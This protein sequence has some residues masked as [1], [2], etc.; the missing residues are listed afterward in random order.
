MNIFEFLKI[1][2]L[3]SPLDYKL[4]DIFQSTSNNKLKRKVF[5]AM[6]W[7]WIKSK[8]KKL[9]KQL[10][11]AKDEILELKTKLCKFDNEKLDSILQKANLAKGKKNSKDN[12]KAKEEDKNEVILPAKLNQPTLVKNSIE[13]LVKTIISSNIISKPAQKE[14][15]CII[16]KQNF[17]NLLN[18]FSW[19]E[20]E[21]MSILLSTPWNRVI[22]GENI[23]YKQQDLLLLRWAAYIISSGLKVFQK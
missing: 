18:V 7:F 17:K 1:Y 16:P 10:S 22:K 5:H 4:A 19:T 6:S 9:A 23:Y 12:N 2:T 15:E 8:D 11:K 14:E 21:E 13:D 20:S 3:A